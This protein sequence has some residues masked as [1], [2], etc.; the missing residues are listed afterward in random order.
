[1]EEQIAPPSRVNEPEPLGRQLLNRALRHFGKHPLDPPTAHHLMPNPTP[2]ITTHS[3]FRQLVLPRSAAPLTPGERIE[4]ARP[5]STKPRNT[6]ADTSNADILPAFPFK[7]A[8]ILDRR[9]EMSKKDRPPWP[10]PLSPP[11]RR[12]ESQT[13]VERKQT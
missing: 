2:D 6:R 13:G 10:V 9:E 11:H 3:D 4:D 5:Y 1:M 7:R 12:S 8:T